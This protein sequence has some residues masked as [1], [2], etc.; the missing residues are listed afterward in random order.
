MQKETIGH[1]FFICNFATIGSLST[2]CTT[3]QLRAISRFWKLWFYN[4][5]LYNFYDNTIV[6]VNSKNTMVLI[7]FV[8]IRI[9][10]YDIK[11]K[12]AML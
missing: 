2:R 4:T 11:Q 12:L 7:N 6:L 8:W 5:I 1:L 10:N 3:C 9:V